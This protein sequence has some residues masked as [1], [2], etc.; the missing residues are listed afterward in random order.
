MRGPLQIC[1]VTGGGEGV[2][3]GVTLFSAGRQRVTSRQIEDPAEF[4]RKTPSDFGAEVYRNSTVDLCLG[5]SAAKDLDFHA[6]GRPRGKRQLGTLMNA[7][8]PPA[9][10][11]V[12]EA[13]A[14]CS[15]RA[16]A[17][18]RV[19]TLAS[20]DPSPVIDELARDHCGK[21]VLIEA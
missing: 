13:D 16:R 19:H 14:L 7:E 15:Q 12:I 18:V 9:A 1:G 3:D 5:E 10:Q 20:A 17:R 8:A 2:V 21:A 4:C 6:G 11:R